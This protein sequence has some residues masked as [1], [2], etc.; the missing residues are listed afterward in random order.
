MLDADVPRRQK[1]PSQTMIETLRITL[2]TANKRHH[3]HDLGA[4]L[5]AHLV[6]MISPSDALFYCYR[7]L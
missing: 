4:I 2:T 1:D 7:K 3:P 5:T 6:A